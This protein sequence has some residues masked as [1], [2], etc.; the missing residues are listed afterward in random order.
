MFGVGNIKI[1]ANGKTP[2]Q[3]KAE[4]MEQVAKQVDTMI[5]LGDKVH[6]KEVKKEEP[7]EVRYVHICADEAEDKSGFGVST[8]WN[9]D[10]STVMTMLTTAVSQA[11][12]NMTNDS[13]DEY[14]PDLLLQ[15]IM[16]LIGEYTGM[17]DEEEE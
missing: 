17:N 3:V 16:A 11:L 1:D 10:F 13:D 7:K 9:G 12:H 5:G 14:N 15:F 8:E 6:K 2:E 4:I